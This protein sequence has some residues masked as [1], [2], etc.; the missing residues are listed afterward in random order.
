MS[1]NIRGAILINFLDKQHVDV[2]G[3]YLI[4]TG[5][6]PAIKVAAILLYLLTGVGH[7]AGQTDKQNKTRGSPHNKSDTPIP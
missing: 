4:I 1:C 6:V 7:A 2:V 3:S 5:D